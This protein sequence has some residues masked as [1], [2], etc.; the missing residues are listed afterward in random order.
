MLN[1]KK[2][3]LFIAIPLMLLVLALIVSAAPIAI[4][5]I[6]KE[7]ISSAEAEEIALEKSGFSRENVRFERTELDRERGQLIYDV[8]FEYN[9]IE[10]SYEIDA[11]TKKIVREKIEEDKKQSPPPVTTT[12]VINPS[13][14]EK[15]AAEKPTATELTREQAIELALAHAGLTRNSVRELEAE[16][17]RE[18]GV[19]V[20]EIEFEHGKTEY[21]YEIRISDGVILDHKVEI[22]D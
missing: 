20:Y 7:R 12:P 14:T 15:P 5:E 3:S 16:K 6:T 13:T 18:R 17:D 19:L 11:Y 21:E 2:L 9:N 1:K 10:Y 22:D 4:N 8:E